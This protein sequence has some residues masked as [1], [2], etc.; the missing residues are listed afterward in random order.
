MSDFRNDNPG[1]ARAF[2]ALLDLASQTRRYARGLPAQVDI[3]PHWSGIGFE[4]LGR[5]FVAPMGE[6]SEMLEVPGHTRLPGVQSWVRGVANV[7]GRLLPLCDLARF[8]GQRLNNPR[9]QQRVLILEQGDLYTGLLVDQ[10]FGM[11]HFPADAF[12]PDVPVEPAALQPFV[13]GSY[14]QQGREW[15]LFS[16]AQ[17][18]LDSTFMNAAAG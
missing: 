1:G 10:V 2:Q 17:L 14:Q 13:R 7:R 16:P 12:D 4:L 3:K 8:L 6:V 11:Q 18:A 15:L 5:R 9:K